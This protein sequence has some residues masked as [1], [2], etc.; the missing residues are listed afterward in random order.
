MNYGL[1]DIGITTFAPNY[2]ISTKSRFEYEVNRSGIDENVFGKGVKGS[3]FRFSDAK[4][5]K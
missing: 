1:S 4:Y 3:L 5:H 2:L